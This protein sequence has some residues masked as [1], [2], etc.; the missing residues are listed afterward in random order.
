MRAFSHITDGGLL[1]LFQIKDL[2]VFNDFPAGLKH[3]FQ[4][5]E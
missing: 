1:F 3:V 5:A 4:A 2:N